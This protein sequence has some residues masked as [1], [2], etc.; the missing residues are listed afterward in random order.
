MIRERRIRSYDE[1]PS[2]EEPIASYNIQGWVDVRTVA[3]IVSY[4]EDKEIYVNRASDLVKNILTILEQAALKAWQGEDR[5]KLPSEAISYL[6]GHG[7]SMSQ[8]RHDKRA[9]TKIKTAL[10]AEDLATDALDLKPNEQLMAMRYMKLPASVRET[11]SLKEYRAM[12]EKIEQGGDKEFSGA[13][14][15]TGSGQLL[16]EGD[17]V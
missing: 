16:T 5:F 13:L 10:I 8:F 14:P 1:A 9:I 12:V 17:D 11:V 4:L 2:L 3:R 6:E 7:F 15:F